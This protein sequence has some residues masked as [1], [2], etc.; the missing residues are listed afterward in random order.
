MRTSLTAALALCLAA[1]SGTPVA[2]PDDAAVA[3]TSSPDASAAD[4]TSSQDAVTDT[5]STTTE[6]TAPADA[7]ST[8]ASSPDATSDGSILPPP[9]ASGPFADAATTPPW[10]PLDVRTDTA[11]PALAACGGSVVGG[12]NV[13]GGCIDLPVPS[14][15]M[16]CP[17]ARVSSTSG[18]AR[19][20]VTFGPLI[21][22][23]AAEWIV[24]AEVFIPAL[25]AAVVGGCGA[26]QSAIRGTIPDSACVTTT[27]GDCRC[28][29]RQQGSIS[30]GDGYVTRANQIVSASLRK[31]WDYCVDGTRLRYRDVSGTG[32]REPGTIE[33]TR[34]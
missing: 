18:R 9:D 17:G 31:T 20:T 27:A 12:W 19:G 14:D 4:A 26:I 30:D 8:D 10:V 29:V 34:R 3:D 25:C 15:L 11:C 5:G 22:Q 7:S 13:S 6:V 32:T 33:L 23:R 24:E 1:C 21:A 28:A 16:R 2:G